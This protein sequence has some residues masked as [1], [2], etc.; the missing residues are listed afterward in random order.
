MFELSWERWLLFGR[1]Q[2][3]QTKRQ[4]V[5]SSVLPKTSWLVL[6]VAEG[7]SK[8]QETEKCSLPFFGKESVSLGQGRETEAEGWGRPLLEE[9]LDG[10][11]M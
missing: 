2:G 10:S 3:E 7:C 11:E 8:L 6:E 5:W 9:I 1:E 4:E